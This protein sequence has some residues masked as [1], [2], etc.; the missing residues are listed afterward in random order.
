[1]Y[2]A[3]LVKPEG[4]TS[5]GGIQFPKQFVVGMLLLFVVAAAVAEVRGYWLLCDFLGCFFLRRL[6]LESLCCW[7]PDCQYLFD[8]ELV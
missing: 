8:G 1:M 4:L 2:G 7:F 3:V 5:V 6:L